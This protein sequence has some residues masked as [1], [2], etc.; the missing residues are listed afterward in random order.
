MRFMIPFLALFRVTEHAKVGSQIV[1]LKENWV[2][3]REHDPEKPIAEMLRKSPTPPRVIIT[4]YKTKLEGGDHFTVLDDER[5]GYRL[6]TASLTNGYLLLGA[7][8]RRRMD[9]LKQ[10][11]NSFPCTFLWQKHRVDSNNI[12]ELVEKTKAGDLTFEFTPDAE[13]ASIP[14]RDDDE[15]KGAEAVFKRTGEAIANLGPFKTTKEQMRSAVDK[16]Y[17][18]YMLKDWPSLQ[19]PALD[20]TTPM[21][22]AKDPACILQ[23]VG[24]L[25]ELYSCH[26]PGKHLSHRD[27]GRLIDKLGLPKDIRIYNSTATTDTEAIERIVRTLPSAHELHHQ[28][29]SRLDGSDEEHRKRAALLVTAKATIELADQMMEKERKKRR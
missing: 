3:W 23:L 20:G 5:K 1:E 14:L 21:E 7:L 28:L 2:S 12:P 27:F 10:V 6:G 19:I 9:K 15:D 18:T 22:A 16:G 24:L 8:N 13:F 4:D 29:Q 17:V 11:V 25:R 26:V